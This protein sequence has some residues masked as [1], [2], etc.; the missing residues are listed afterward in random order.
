MKRHVSSRILAGL[1][2]TIL[3]TLSS[4]C[5]TSCDD[6]DYYWN[7]YPPN[8]WDNTFYDSR[9]N[10]YWELVS[11]NSI[12]IGAYDTNWL[13]FNG[14]GRG[15]YY[16]YLNSE[17]YSENTAYWC[18]VSGGPSTYQ[19]NLQYENGQA[20]TMSYWFDGPSVLYMQWRNQSGLQT[21]VYR[22]V[23][24]APW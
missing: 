20:S 9:L 6:D 19:I 22:R 23:A 5:F 24:Y 18:Q 3:A 8:G 17:R 10:G 7:P 12:A 11:T 21:Y 14:S 15:V 4:L 1:V 16:Y 2:L 13:F